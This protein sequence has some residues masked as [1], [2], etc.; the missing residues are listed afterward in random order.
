VKYLYLNL[1]SSS[2]IVVG[3]A[4]KKEEISSTKF[5]IGQSGDFESANK[6]E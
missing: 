5:I 4:I 2:S 6:V 1:F 3:N